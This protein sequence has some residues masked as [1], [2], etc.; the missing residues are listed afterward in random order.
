[1]SPSP[2][3]PA[4]HP[5]PKPA[6][7]HHGARPVAQHLA[8][9]EDRLRSIENRLSGVANGPG[10]QLPQ[11]LHRRLESLE[12]REHHHAQALA[13]LESRLAVL[14]ARLTEEGGADGVTRDDNGAQVDGPDD[15]TAAVFP[16]VPRRSLGRR[17]LD[18]LHYLRYVWRRLKGT[19]EGPFPDHSLRLSVGDPVDRLPSLGVVVLA[20]TAPSADDLGAALDRQ[21]ERE[22]PIWLYVEQEQSLS[23]WRGDMVAEEQFLAP[24]RLRHHMR[25]SAQVDYL[26]TCTVDQLSSWPDT[27]VECLRL[28]LAAEELDLVEV[29]LPSNRRLLALRSTAW[30]PPPGIISSP[31]ERP[32]VQAIGKVVRLTPE[33]M[34]ALL[35]GVF[36]RRFGPYRFTKPGRTLVRHGLVPETPSGDSKPGQGAAPL[37]LTGQLLGGREQMFSDLL[38]RLGPQRLVLTAGSD[39][40][41][42]ERY[43]RLQ[44]LRRLDGTGGQLYPLTSFLEAPQLAGAVAW[45]ARRWACP[46]LLS[47][48]N[49]ASDQEVAAACGEG[50]LPSLEAPRHGAGFVLCDSLPGV[51]QR[52]AEVA[53]D[54]LRQRLGVAPQAPV[55]LWFGDLL[56]ERRP[57]D[58][59][60]L[61]QR[62]QGTAEAYFLM[63]GRGPLEGSVDDLARFLG[64]D[65]FRRLPSLPLT[66]A[67]ALCDVLCLTASYEPF[68]HGL[69]AALSEGRPVLLPGGS[70]MASWVSQR[71]AGPAATYD[72]TDLDSAVE[73]LGALLAAT[74]EASPAASADDPGSEMQDRG[75]SRRRLGVE[76][77]DDRWR[78]RLESPPP[79]A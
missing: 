29:L 2:K 71:A 30:N 64:L 61:A 42:L 38:L 59:L 1:M 19:E 78:Q 3:N 54:A 47:L 69:L 68:P 26:I 25:Q 20:E 62:W 48:A 6:A 22:L 4:A 18:A 70:E 67:I 60:S 7:E 51:G 63:V 39:P 27:V 49:D 36:E 43:H 13:S 8:A 40:L 45:L 35:D 17:A 58:F 24:E 14:L 75:S 56:R 9:I 11:H 16:A 52:T 50:S 53:L 73:A 46:A 15:G 12:S 21:T 77:H 55:I 65:R 41:T 33:P 66:F 32:A 23:H 31:Q 57:E 76:D 34:A 10:K 5:D 37:L 79:P 44:Q 74:A 28:T 72:S